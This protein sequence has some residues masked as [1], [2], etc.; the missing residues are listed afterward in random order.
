MI[1]V[2]DKKIKKMTER[3]LIE[4]AIIEKCLGWYLRITQP[5]LMA[6]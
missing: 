2:N 1:K 4:K 3:E 6:K 5:G